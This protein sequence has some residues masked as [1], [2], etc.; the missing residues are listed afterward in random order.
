M[1]DI[2]SCIA[3]DIIHRVSNK[4]M[5]VYGKLQTVREG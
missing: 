4:G 3:C 1:F 5:E 2:W